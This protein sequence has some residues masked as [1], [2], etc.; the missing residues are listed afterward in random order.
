M[1]LMRARVVILLFCLLIATV[2]LV[3]YN[4]LTV[5]NDGVSIKSV[6]FNSQAMLAGIS[7]PDELTQPIHY[8][9]IKSINGVPINSL[10]DYDSVIS[11]TPA[12]I[13]ML[14]ITN[15]GQYTVLNDGDIGLTVIDQANSNLRLGLDLS[16][17]TRVL[18][19]PTEPVSD[20]VLDQIVDSLDNRL[21]VYG[22]SDV[23]I[24]KASDLFSED[25]FIVVEIAGASQSEVTNLLQS[26]G[27]FE[28]KIA[29]VTVFSGDGDDITYVC[30]SADCSGI[31]PFRGCQEYQEG[32]VCG[33]AFSITLSSE[34]AE[35]QANITNQLQVLGDAN[36]YYLSENL[37]F[38]LDDVETNSLQIS[39]NLKGKASTNIQITGSGSGL[40]QADAMDSALQDMKTMQ[41]I[42]MT[43]SLPVDL[44]I[45]RMDTI[46]ATLGSEFLVNLLFIGLIALIAVA[47]IIYI[48]YRKI[49]LT[50]TIILTLISEIVLILG[51]AA[52]FKWQLDL[53]A[54]AG[55]L[56]VIG[57]GI[58]HLIIITD[59]MLNGTRSKNV[60]GR[61]K[62]AMAIVLGA[63]V[64]TLAGMLPLF[65]AGAGLLKGF[66]FT[67]IVGVSA[68]V[69]IA[70]PAFASVLETL[71]DTPDE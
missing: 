64:T 38:Y 65:N 26:Q 49:E 28:A 67:T 11:T 13:S 33:Y 34:S 50:V 7:N 8:E 54:V 29:N 1:K 10:E 43:G 31:D 46:S 4:P 32:Y 14:I 40:S 66:A 37:I 60:K 20:E 61:I 69:L 39:A 44:E 68:G 51:F 59:E 9:V 71:F 63:Y 2:A 62:D 42:L 53:A 25:Q 18:L 15:Q 41:T 57:T 35:R 58:D 48:K 16:G 6:S 22:V 30:R 12:N 3:G 52:F 17:G 36:N 55:I 45:V 21:N 5:F 24:T 70:R 19:S 56:L 47:S 23:V 27:K